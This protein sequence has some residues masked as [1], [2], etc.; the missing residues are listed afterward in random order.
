MSRELMR[1]V[2]ALVGSLFLA[3]SAMADIT[4][5]VFRDFN[6]NG[7][8][9]NTASFS[10][11]GVAGITVT[12]WSANGTVAGVPVTTAADGTYTLTG[13]VAGAE[14]RVEFTGIPD[15]LVAGACNK[16][17]VG[18]SG[19]TVAFAQDGASAVNA[20]LSNPSDYCQD[21]PDM[22][23]TRFVKGA[24][25]SAFPPNV[26]SAVFAYSY[27]N[28]ASRSVLAVPSQVGA[29]Y[30][31]AHVPKANVTLVSSFFKRHADLGPEGVAAIYR[32]DRASGSVSPYAVLDGS[33]PRNAGP[34]YDWNHDP[35]GFSLVGKIG[36]GDIELSDDQKAL[37][38]VN[39]DDRKLYTFSV[40]ATASAQA[41][42]TG[43]YDIPRNDC[44]N[45]ADARPM[46][47]GFHD[48]QL[49]VGVTCT[50]EST[51]DPDNADDSRNGPRWGDPSQLD[52]F[53]YRFDPFAHSF[54]QV[55]HIPLGYTRGCIWESAL[56][57]PSNETCNAEFHAN[58]LPWQPDYDIV[59]GDKAPGNKQGWDGHPFV[60]GYNPSRY[61]EYPQPLLSDIVFDNDGSMIVL[62]RDING[63][64]TGYENHSPDPAD[65]ETHRGNGMGDV[66]R[67]CGNAQS[68]WVL[69]NGGSCS[70]P[71]GTGNHQGP[72]DGE[73]YWQ[74]N[75]PGGPGAVA[76]NGDRGHA[77]TFMGGLLHIPGYK[78]NVSG[79]MDV[80]TYWESGL[81]WFRNDD[82]TTVM[83][84]GTP[85]R[86][87]ISEND[88]NWFYG[89]AGGIGDIEA[90]CEPAPIEIGNFVWHDLNHNGIQDPGE[91]PLAGVRVLL[92]EGANQVGSVLT[93][94]QGQFYFGGINNANMSSG[95]LKPETD[96]ELRISLSPADNPQ[97]ANKRP[98]LQNQGTDLHDSDGDN[99]VLHAGYSSIA[100]TTGVPGANTHVLDFGFTSAVALG[101]RVWRDDGA[102]GGTINNGVQDGS[103]AGIAGVELQLYRVGMAT[104]VASTT[105]DSN[106]YYFFDNLMPGDYYLQIPASEFASGQPL[107]NLASSSGADGTTTVDLND[108]GIDNANRKVNGIRSNVFSLSVGGEPT[109][110]DQTGYSGNLP[111]NSVNATYD[112]G[113]YDPVSTYIDL[114]LV[115][116]VSGG[117]VYKPGDVVTFTLTVSN[118]GPAN[119]TG[120]EVTDFVPDGFEGITN[121]SNGGT[122][123][124]STVV[125][126]GLNITA[127]AS[128]SLH[129]DA[130]LRASGSHN[131]R[132]EV[133]DANEHDPDSTPGNQDP[134]EDD[135][136]AVNLP[137]QPT[138]IPGLSNW[139]LMLLSSMLA[140]LGWRIRIRAKPAINP[141]G[142]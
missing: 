116:T 94:A 43:S 77:D 118:A 79:V 95:R 64:R 59:F 58:W 107:A 100:F 106:G 28:T 80:T 73:Y 25:G 91:P 105:T 109:G 67:A 2:C 5:T 60:P 75:G 115:K 17:G 26:D 32:I 108:N 44:P 78:D 53:V 122:S 89:K 23:I 57:D 92:F 55:L 97:L 103:E 24:R 46:G 87:M 125:W 41:A 140:V 130:M 40:D 7:R 99:G 22:V 82:G 71:G 113:F 30:G 138:A 34:T 123:V 112:F 49:Y 131:N 63:D 47:L 9:D 29:V 135:F 83:N 38:V 139:V 20:S 31:I 39:L 101:N 21:D 96:Y 3:S 128:I 110:E 124:G 66:L 62:L 119:A 13:L 88:S 48:G 16:G 134:G 15:Y 61:I 11:P 1:F 127:G 51:V 141:G 50:A 104:A 10:E 12:A 4:G 72:A 70:T 27:A 142:E 132:A 52:A 19:T 98:T 85:R 90:L 74:D 129:F 102:G 137:V 42:P 45:P 6:A 68:G 36:L 81:I 126:T 117:P 111:D 93:D 56:S 54:A 114:N 84:G 8:Q 76:A 121:I 120:V 37:F 33:D 18:E 86:M 14:Y 133:T 136:S 69:E 35:G 65:T